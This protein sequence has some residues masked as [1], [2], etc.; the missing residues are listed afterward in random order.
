MYCTITRW[1]KIRPS[2]LDIFLVDSLP[3]LWHKQII[4]ILVRNTQYQTVHSF[5]TDDFVLGLYR[6][7]VWKGYAT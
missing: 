2:M 5:S 4:H 6:S 7:V 3:H 1:A